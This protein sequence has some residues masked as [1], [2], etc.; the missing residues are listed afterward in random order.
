MGT[1]LSASRSGRCILREIFPGAHRAFGRRLCEI[2]SWSG[3]SEE[4][5]N[6]CCRESKN[7]SADVQ[8]VA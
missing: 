2:L 4:P 8:P 6:I 5:K 7:D 3:L 1:E